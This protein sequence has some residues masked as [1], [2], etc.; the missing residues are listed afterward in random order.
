[1]LVFPGPAQAG[2]LS[3]VI[4]SVALGHL[5]YQP[6]SENLMWGKVLPQMPIDTEYWAFISPKENVG[7]W[8]AG[9]VAGHSVT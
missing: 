1:M 5:T 6:E 4:G 3:E 7:S 9:V 8:R 2:P